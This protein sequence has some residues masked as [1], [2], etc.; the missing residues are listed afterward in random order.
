V[1]TNEDAS[2]DVEPTFGEVM[3]YEAVERLGLTGD[4]VEPTFGEVMSYEAVERLGLTGEEF[5]ALL[6]QG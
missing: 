4:D 3:S 1:R 5:E 6:A 2:D